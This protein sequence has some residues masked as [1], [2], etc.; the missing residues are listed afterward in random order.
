MM[1]LGCKTSPAVRQPARRSGAGRPR[2]GSPGSGRWRDNWWLER[3]GA[4]RRAEAP[5]VG[6]RDALVEQAG[7]RLVD[8]E[9]AARAVPPQGPDRSPRAGLHTACAHRPRQYREAHRRGPIVERVG[10]GPTAMADQ[11]ARRSTPSRRFDQVPTDPGA[12]AR[13]RGQLPAWAPPEGARA[14][15]GE[16]LTG[17]RP[18]RSTEPP[19]GSGRHDWRGRS[20]TSGSAGGP[21]HVAGPAGPSAC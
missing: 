15:H 20:A 17:P 14:P 18:L 10:G 7:R 6:A 1:L 4:G 12:R 13:G 21:A 8:D 3:L 5:A 9:Q 11:D 19:P 2:P 16:W